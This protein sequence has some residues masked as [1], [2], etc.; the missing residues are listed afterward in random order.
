MTISIRGDFGGT[1]E[2]ADIYIN[3]NYMAR[4]YASG[5]MDCDS[6]WYTCG[7][8]D[9]IQQGRLTIEA[10]TSSAVNYCSPYAEMKS[11]L[12]LSGII[13]IFPSFCEYTS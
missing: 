7:T 11:E 5:S 12:M 13:L 3:G 1:D 2:Y 4:C 8:Y 9:N 6:T 10:R